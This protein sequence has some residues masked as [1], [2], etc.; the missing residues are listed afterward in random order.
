MNSRPD[1]VGVV[2]SARALGMIV[3]LTGATGALPV[4]LGRTG[5]LGGAADA[6]LGL[7]LF[8]LP[9]AW[10]GGPRRRAWYR[11]RL[12][13]A[14][15]VPPGAVLT[16]PEDT[17]QRV[18]R[19]LSRTVAIVLVIELLVAFGTGVPF[20][21][22]FAGVGVGMLTQ[23]S[24]LARQERTRGIRL[25]C[26]VAPGRVAADDP[27]LEVYRAVPFYTLDADAPVAPGA[28]GST[29]SMTD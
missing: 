14:V 17:F 21:L 16:A 5:D 19:P 7:V 11:D 25:F 26:P 3:L 2:G 8:C 15:P 22:A 12:T 20:G 23:G 4:L 10:Y 29:D 28:S 13:A 27:N 18:T 6:V 24:W 1:L 9:L